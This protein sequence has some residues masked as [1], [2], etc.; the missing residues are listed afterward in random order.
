MKRPPCA[1]IYTSSDGAFSHCDR[2]R[3]EQGPCWKQVG[4]ALLVWRWPR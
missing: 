3:H 4:R 1:S 2:L